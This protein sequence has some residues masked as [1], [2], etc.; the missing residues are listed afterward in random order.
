MKKITII[1]GGNVGATT[2]QLCAYKELGDI[3]LIDRIEGL[4]QGKCLDILESAPLERFD[5][6]I[7]GSNDYADA[8]NSDVV[9]ITA[10]RPRTPGMTRADLIHINYEIVKSVTEQIMA[11][12]PNAF[13]IITTNPLDTMCY[14]AKKVGGLKRERI[15]GMSGVL[16]SAR[17]RTFIALELKVAPEDVQAMVLGSHGE[18]MVPLPRCSTV[19]GI[20]ITTLLTAEQIERINQ[21]TIDG[22]K[23]I[24]SL[25]KSGSAY[26]APAS[27][28]VHMVES[29]IKNKERV[30]PCSV[31]LEGEY[32]IEGTFTGVPAKL[33]EK[34]MEGVIEFPLTDEEHKALVRSANRVKEAI[35]E[36]NIF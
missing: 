18:D 12:S 10:G 19:S 33:G 34:G 9:V 17:M 7:M 11:V 23:E 13:F 30:V 32:G 2:A 5:S 29:V 24:V 6:T 31:Y 3:V 26:Y 35:K 4:S 8:A 16:D 21:R 27:S 15:V 14:V 25:L 28:I 20:P 36:L 22:G 1:G